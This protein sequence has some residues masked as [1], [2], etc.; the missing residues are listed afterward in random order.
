M[1]YQKTIHTMAIIKGWNM[2]LPWLELGMFKE[3]GEL[4]DAIE[5]E[6][7]VAQ[8]GKEFGDVMFFLLQTM[9]HYNIDLDKALQNVIER[10]KV[11]KKKTLING[12]IVRR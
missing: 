9:Q 4:V 3:V 12:E 5:H 6:H 7:E 8:V 10:N 1:D 11:E 2:D